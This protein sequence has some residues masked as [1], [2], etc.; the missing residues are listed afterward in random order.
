MVKDSRSSEDDY[1]TVRVGQRVE[2]LDDG[3][4]RAW[5]VLTLPQGPGEQQEEG[6]LP[7]SCLRKV[8]AV[9]VVS[10]SRES[11]TPVEQFEAETGQEVP[12]GMAR[13]GKEEVD[14]PRTT[15]SDDRPLTSQDRPSNHVCSE[16]TTGQDLTSPLNPQQP[17]PDYAALT[18]SQ[19]SL[20]GDTAEDQREDGE[21]TTPPENECS[22]LVEEELPSSSGPS[23][24][25]PFSPPPHGDLLASGDMAS[26]YPDSDDGSSSREASCSPPM[27]PAHARQQGGKPPR[28]PLLKG[29]VL[30][31][32]LHSLPTTFS[33]SS[34][35]VM[36]PHKFLG[37]N[38][39][40]VSGG[41]QMEVTVTFDLSPQ[42]PTLT[43]S[44]PN[45]PE[46]KIDPSCPP[47]RHRGELSQLQWATVKVWMSHD[48][49]NY[50]WTGIVS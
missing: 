42:I 24:P 50:P 3:N 32:S 44:Q 30:S 8:K 46:I 37:Y 34:T 10:Q 33:P 39:M 18:P 31:S 28:L 9:S 40:M 23:Q 47:H 20:T 17:L 21:E 27:H 45:I 1:L 5:L 4:E 26:S 48:H 38:P 19:T 12:Q 15:P 22:S 6:F 41:H 43:M 25:L 2:V 35:P 7:P 13:G 49:Y 29:D 11:S 36:T 16:E 14:A